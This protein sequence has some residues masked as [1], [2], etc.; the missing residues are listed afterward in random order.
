MSLIIYS[1]YNSVSYCHDCLK[2]LKFIRLIFHLSYDTRIS[3]FSKNQSSYRKNIFR[4]YFY[5]ISNIRVKEVKC[6]FLYIV[7]GCAIPCRYRWEIRTL[8]VWWYLRFIIFSERLE[9]HVFLILRLI[10]GSVIQNTIENFFRQPRH[11]RHLF[12]LSS[13]LER[14]V[15]AL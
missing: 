10:S 1:I 9:F 11:L 13:P 5:F 7:H 15:F 14:S 2:L 6:I 12:W 3:I 4:L 8:Y